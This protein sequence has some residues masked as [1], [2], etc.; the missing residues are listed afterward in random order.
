MPHL[1]R[2]VK[3]V[4]SGPVILGKHGLRLC[5]GNYPL[6]CIRE[7]C[8]GLMWVRGRS[9]VFCKISLG[10]LAHPRLWHAN[11]PLSPQTHPH[12]FLCSFSWL[13]VCERPKVWRPLAVNA[14]ERCC[15]ADRKKTKLIAQGCMNEC[16]NA[17][18][19]LSEWLYHS[20]T[21][22]IYSHDS[23]VR[24]AHNSAYFFPR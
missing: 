5:L 4:L 23:I 12:T 16:V 19:W 6:A 21:T 14:Q 13:S 24:H 2:T 18:G 17:C 1:L 22:W 11:K 9:V 10:R 3:Q 20:L 15:D 8:N 7:N